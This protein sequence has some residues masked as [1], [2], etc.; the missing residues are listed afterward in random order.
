MGAPPK[1]GILTKEKVMK[2]KRYESM[3]AKLQFHVLKC[4]RDSKM[5]LQKYYKPL[6]TDTLQVHGKRAFLEPSTT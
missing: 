3:F 4:P 1:K 2:I 6:Q 5:T